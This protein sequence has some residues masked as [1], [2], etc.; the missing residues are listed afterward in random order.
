[1]RII[2]LG[3]GVVGITAAWHLARDGHEVVVVDRQERAAMETSFSNAGMVSPGHA[4][5][6]AS[7]RAPKILW[8]SLFRQD[9][10]LRLK[11]SLD[12]RLYAWGLRFLRECS[13]GRAAINT[14][15]KVRLC[16][17]SQKQFEDLA[18]ELPLDYH[19]QTG[20]AL[21]LYRDAD[22][23]ARG[24]SAMSI[25]TDNGVTLRGVGPA[26]IAAI[27][28]ALSDE[29]K[30]LAG[31]IYCPT[32]ESGD[33]HRF[34]NLL[35]ADAEQRLGVTFLWN[36]EIRRIEREGDRVTQIVTSEGPVTGDA[37]VLAMGSFSPA[38]ARPLGFDMPIYPVKGFA[39]TAPVESSNAAPQLCGVDEKYLVAWSRL[40][41]RIRVTATAEF[42]GFDRSHSERDFAHMLDT[43]RGLFPRA[44]AY[45]KATRWAGL[46]PMTPKGTP[47]IGASPLRNLWLNTGHGHIGW[48]MSMGSGRLLADV[49][50]GRRTEIAMDGLTLA[51]A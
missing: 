5:T 27:E 41:D 24:L 42:S 1:M 31:A 7:P 13:A 10:A 21:Y 6:W 2:V 32:D 16:L 37:Y 28:P 39:L 23:Y 51:D 38:A 8:Q 45:D 33:C 40:G 18:A 25:L 50:A 19:R 29:A 20:G 35:A 46:R 43:V 36:R 4:Y 26:E 22:H 44:A 3:A 15:H 30:S 47:I 49:V 48:T 14:A 11:P 12:W 34:T 17:Y 9:T